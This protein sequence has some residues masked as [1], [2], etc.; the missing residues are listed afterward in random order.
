MV[1]VLGMASTKSE[2]PKAFSNFSKVES[3]GLFPFSAFWM[4]PI[5]T[6]MILAKSSCDIPLIFLPSLILEW[7]SPASSVASLVMMSIPETPLPVTRLDCS[8]FWIT[9]VGLCSTTN[10]IEAMHPEQHSRTDCDT[11]AL[12]V[13]TPSFPQS[14]QAPIL[15]RSMGAT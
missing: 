13:P 1:L 3:I 4:T 9:F 11:F 6:F 12:L 14:S 7:K 5:L 2:I 8:L 10:P 15:Q